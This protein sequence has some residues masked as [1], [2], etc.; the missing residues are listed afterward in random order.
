MMRVNTVSG[1]C[2]LI[3]SDLIKR[4]G[5]LDVAFAPAFQEDV[6]YSFRTWRAGFNV[7]YQPDVMV[8]H[9]ERVSFEGKRNPQAAKNKKYWTV[10]NSMLVCLMYFSTWRT[11][12]LGLPIC[13][14]SSV[15]P[16]GQAK[17]A[18]NHQYRAC[19]NPSRVSR[20][21]VEQLPRCISDLP[22]QEVRPARRK[23]ERAPRAYTHLNYKC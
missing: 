12:G 5:L 16:E 3:K 18:W 22:L 19:G 23:I 6:E 13:S 7:L 17:K 15:R 2:M 9:R 4:I 1:A 8:V 21:V 11:L 20:Y 10:R 14:A